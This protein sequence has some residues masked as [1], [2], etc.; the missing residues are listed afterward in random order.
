MPFNSIPFLIFIILFFL[1]WPWAKKKQNFRYVFIVVS[2]FVFYGWWDWRFLFLILFSGLVDFYAARLI[3]KNRKRAKL[4]FILSILVN[5][6]SLGVFKYSSFFA[7]QVENLLALF[8]VTVHLKEQL[9]AF[10]LILPIGISFYTFQ[11]MSYTIDVYRGRL[12]PTKNIAHFFSYLVM[13]PQLVAGPIVRAKDFLKQLQK[14]RIV[15]KL[16]FWHGIKLIVIGYF[17]KTVLADNLGVIVNTAF[18]GVGTGT[19]LYWWVVMICFSFQIYFD[20]NGYSLIARGLAKLMGYHFKMNF[21]HPYLATSLRDFWNRWHISLSTW[22][23]DYIYIPLGGSKR[24]RI[25]SHI[26][27][28]ITMFLSGLWHGAAINFVLWGV[29]HGLILSIER[30]VNGSLKGFVEIKPLGWI[31]TMTQVLV[32]WVFFRSTSLEQI[33]NITSGMITM[34][35]SL[36]FLVTNENTMLFLLLAIGYEWAY[37]LANTHVQLRRFKNN[38]YVEASAYAILIVLIVFFRGPETEF[39]YFQF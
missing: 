31:L 7:E 37:Y 8:S 21:D 29:Y 14:Y 17:Q 9:P 10:T 33:F 5:L 24:S 16:E 11:S 2:S 22:F 34:D 39:I 1:L 4:Y 12:Q 19:G 23:R 18:E 26:N 38:R 27:L 30:L 13:F 3:Y 6:A 25:R 35:F 20:F 36:G 32:G 28:W 15:S